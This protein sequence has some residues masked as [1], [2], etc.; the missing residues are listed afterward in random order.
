MNQPKDSGETSSPPPS[1][2]GEEL[3]RR[4]FITAASA[5]LAAITLSSGRAT[6]QNIPEVIDAE[7]GPSANDPG[8]EN[9]LMREA[10]PSRFIPP[11]TDRGDVEQFWNSFSIQH[12]RIQ[13][14]GWT[15]QSRFPRILPELTCA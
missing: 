10:S 15:R 5:A 12:R 14:G 9:K 2:M 4:Q 1:G 11:P 7:N 13:P 3:G 6:A 8:P